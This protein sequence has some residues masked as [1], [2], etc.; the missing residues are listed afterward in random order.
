MPWQEIKRLK[1]HM[2][3]KAARNSGPQMTPEMLESMMDNPSDWECNGVKLD[4]L[5]KKHGVDAHTFFKYLVPFGMENAMSHAI[6][7]RKSIVRHIARLLTF[8]PFLSLLTQVKTFL[9]FARSLN[10]ERRCA[11]RAGTWPA[12][13]TSTL[14]R[15]C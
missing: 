4:P 15:R 12:S 11:S 9:F 14:L 10:W 6:E 3:S 8:H 7:H 5:L 1:E 2:E 13:A